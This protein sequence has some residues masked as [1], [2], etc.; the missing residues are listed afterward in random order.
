M[1]SSEGL[2]KRARQRQ[3]WSQEQAIVRFEAISKAM[4]MLMPAR[5][6]LRTLL[7]VFENNRRSVPERYRQVF[8]E[9][10]RATDEEL[11]FTIARD[12]FDV[13]ISLSLAP[14]AD[15]S[16]PPEIFG[17]LSS[18]LAEQVRVDTYIGP[19]YLIPAVRSQLSLIDQVI[20][21]FRGVDRHQGLV[22]AAKTAE[23]CGWLYQDSGDPGAAAFWT[24]A[25]LDY[26]HELSDPQLVSYV[27][28][29]K[30]NIATEFGTPG[31]GLGLANAAL[32]AD[33]SLTP[34]LKAVCLRQKANAHAQLSERREFEEAIDG[35]MAAADLG[36]RQ[37]MSDNAS[38]CTPSYVAM[39]AGMSRLQLGQE[40]SA[41]EIFE[42]SLADWPGETQTRDRGICLARLAVA[43]ST[44]GQ[45]ERACEAGTQALAI[46]RSTGSARL[47]SHLVM[48]YDNLAA[49]KGNMGVQ[50]FR[51]GLATFLYPGQA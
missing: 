43:T 15:Q 44:A 48:V 8:R 19:G 28:M 3:G 6:S 7:S 10:Y 18:V 21:R 51:D 2:L 9:L 34:R 4:G 14:A 5:A 11:G 22:V 1:E 32:T 17:Y 37:E 46:A 38:Y 23:F 25:S 45:V 40:E 16:P 35:A 47:R 20:E 49:A 33:D 26:A 24:S 39:E 13:P 50:R 36:A 30:S 12:G 42:R 31:H 41:I 29:R 27:L